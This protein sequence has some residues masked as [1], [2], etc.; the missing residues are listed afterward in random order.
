MMVANVWRKVKKDPSFETTHFILLTAKD[1]KEDK[2]SALDTGAD[3]YLVKPCDPQELMARVRAAERMVTLQRH[4][5]AKNQELKKAM[6]RIDSELDT[7]AQI[8]LSLLP[9]QL[10]SFPNYEFDAYYRPST[11]CS[12]DYY[13][14]F[15][16]SENRFGVVIA[17]V[18]GHGTPAMVAMALARS[19][20]HLFATTFSSPAELLAKIN[21]ELFSLL[22]TTQYLTAF[23]AVCDLRTGTI[24]YSSAGHNPPL[25]VDRRKGMTRYLDHC[26]GF[27]LKLISPEAQYENF[28]FRLEPGQSLLL[29]TDGIPEGSNEQL[30]F[31]DAERL[32]ESA[33]AC[34]EDSPEGIVQCVIRDLLAFTGPV[35][36]ND[37]VTMLLIKRDE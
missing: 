3:E 7:L 18:S 14:V 37:D 2:V 15:K 28:A 5:E 17:D 32:S 16:L 36:W 27:P 23:Y 24:E 20:F 21:R 33:L 19:L 22:P 10:P 35:P 12:G 1:R 29:Y 9:Q 31:F 6:E 34:D 8:Q 4:L 13:D 11:E 30:E 26:E 25:L